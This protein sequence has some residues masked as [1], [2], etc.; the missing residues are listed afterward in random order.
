MDGLHL[1]DPLGS[2]V[3][4]LA[5]GGCFCDRCVARF[6]VYL[7]ARST[8]DRRRSARATSFDGFDYRAFVKEYAPTRRQYLSLQK[9][10]PLNSE[11]RDFQLLCACE[12]V[13]SLGRLAA[14]VA[15]GNVSLSAGASL[16]TLEEAMVIPLLT[17][18]ASEVRHNASDGG[19]KLD[20]AVAAYRLAEA[21]GTPMAITASAA[22]WAHIKHHNA[23]DLVCLWIALAHACG[24]RFMV[25]H[26]MACAVEAGPLE[27]YCGPWSTFAPLYAFV[28]SRAALLN[29]FRAVGPLAK[30][31]F[32]PSS[33]AAAAHRQACAEAL[34]GH[35]AVPIAAG[36][37]AWVFPRAKSDGT[38]AVHVVNRFYD[39][40]VRRMIPQRDLMVR[41]PNEIFKRNYSGATVY[42]SDGEPYK[43]PVSADN[44]NTVFVLP[45]I[46]L[47]SIVTFEYWA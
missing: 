18:C 14:D 46:N 4:A 11:F 42:P 25:P 24:Q 6:A 23:D 37:N 45:E 19:G 27:W 3:S 9:S 35:P 22:D 30:P 15:G 38:A 8:D 33:L 12:N 43:I 36:N 2:A 21:L 13:E 20:A 16:D 41:V 39:H 31:P 34:A 7:S 26:R 28:R 40:N 5:G 17:Y 44:A 47:W 1:D 29:D 10:I 32:M